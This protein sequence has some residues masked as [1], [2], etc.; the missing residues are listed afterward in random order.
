MK[1]N[2]ISSTGLVVFNC[3]SCLFS[4]CVFRFDGFLFY[5]F[6]EGEWI[7]FFPHFYEIQGSIQGLWLRAI[8]QRTKKAIFTY[9]NGWSPLW[10]LYH[11]YSLSFLVSGRFSSPVMNQMVLL[12]L[13]THYLPSVRHTWLV[14]IANNP[15]SPYLWLLFRFMAR[16]RYGE[17]WRGS[18]SSLFT[19][20]PN[21]NCWSL[22]ITP[23][24]WNKKV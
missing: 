4:F 15:S 11:L 12:W 24:W 18:S 16:Y 6:G 8:C 19:S 5:E 7:T 10:S 13:H 3:T 20:A 2:N 9:N 23:C 21:V 17:K 14:L 1:N 22:R